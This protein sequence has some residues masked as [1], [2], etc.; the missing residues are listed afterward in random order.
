MIREAYTVLD[1]K[2]MELFE[3]DLRAHRDLIYSRFLP[4]EPA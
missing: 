2:V 4:R 1:P 3:T